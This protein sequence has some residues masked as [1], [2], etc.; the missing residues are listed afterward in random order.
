MSYQ[1]IL[2]SYYDCVPKE[3]WSVPYYWMEAR[4]KVRDSLDD[5]VHGEVPPELMSA[6][7]IYYNHVLRNYWFTVWVDIYERSRN[8]LL[9]ASVLGVVRA[10]GNRQA[11]ILRL[12]L[13]WLLP[14]GR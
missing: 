2:G 5:L 4:E 10:C 9:P 7:A 14:L 3:F 12:D 8:R 11:R 13:M 6:T 1:G